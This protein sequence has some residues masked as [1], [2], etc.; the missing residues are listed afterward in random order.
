MDADLPFV[1][2]S[3]SFMF[4]FRRYPVYSTL[5][6][7]GLDIYSTSLLAIRI[8]YQDSLIAGYYGFTFVTQGFCH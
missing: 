7:D 6:S 5:Q 2:L 1:I 3:K 8:K 4:I